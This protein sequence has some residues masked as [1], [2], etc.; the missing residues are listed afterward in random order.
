MS[1]HYGHPSQSGDRR[2]HGQTPWWID[3]SDDEPVEPAPP[4]EVPVVERTWPPI[5]LVE[6]TLPPVAPAGR[7]DLEPSAEQTW[8]PIP[9]VRPAEPA[10]VPAVEQT[11]P[12]IPPVEQTLPPVSPLPAVDLT[13]M[14]ST[15]VIEPVPP[16]EIDSQAGWA[17]E[18]VIAHRGQ[19]NGPH[20]ASPSGEGPLVVETSTF[21]M[22]GS[23]EPDTGELRLSRLDEQ[24]AKEFADGHA[25]S[26][27]RRHSNWDDDYE[28]SEFRAEKK[29]RQ[30]LAMPLGWQ[31]RVVELLVALAVVVGAAYCI[32]WALPSV[33][34][35]PAAQQVSSHLL[36][37]CPYVADT[38]ANLI[39]ASSGTATWRPSQGS[40]NN[41]Q[42]PVF[43]QSVLSPATMSGNGSLAGLVQF[44]RPNASAAVACAQPLSTGYLQ[45]NTADATLQLGNVDTA[46][47]ILTVILMGPDGPIDAPGLVDLRIGPASTIG[48]DLGQYA[49]G[50]APLAISWQSTVGRVVAWLRVDGAAGLDLGAPT[51]AD[52]DV[53][54]PAVS[55]D[56]TVLLLLTDPAGARAKAT[57]EA[58][59]GQGSMPVVGGEQVAVEGF[60]TLAL[61]LTNAL[62]GQTTALRVKSDRPLA[63]T[64]IVSQGRDFASV[65]GIAAS[66]LVRPDLLGVLNGP[67]Q[68]VVSNSANQV[69]SVIMTTT[70]INGQLYTHAASIAPGAS[71]VLDIQD[72]TQAIRL[73]GPVGVVAAAIV[74]PD[75]DVTNGIDIIWLTPDPAWGGVTPLWV[76]AHPS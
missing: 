41:L 17:D 10:E 25:R 26:G 8:P 49:P 64:A 54:V 6:Q 20:R 3:T 60:S 16:S 1:Q 57:V 35:Q 30:P 21:P 19:A 47:A 23:N 53:I 27:H 2:S 46:T 67:G 13:D 18:P 4:V 76:E 28:E 43:E 45:T 29:P 74:Y 32:N 22:I 9:P 12:P 42:G 5:P 39:G 72:G 56:A 75:N 50:V 37:S 58:L 33:S 62:E 61:D 55:G 69:A 40:S 51:K 52:T 48:V 38:T 31:K 59:T 7:V 71:V 44:R 65:P 24:M 15:T 36:L 73:N 68:L 66:Q 34:P 11:W 70:D 14:T 63:V